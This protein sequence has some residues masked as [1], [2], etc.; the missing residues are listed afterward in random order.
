M[1]KT[2]KEAEEFCKQ[3][4]KSRN[5]GYIL[6]IEEKEKMS[7]V[8]RGHGEHDEKVGSGIKDIFI[9]KTVFGYKGFY[10]KRLDDSIIDFS[11]HHCLS[12]QKLNGKFSEAYRNAI[13][14]SVMEIQAS[15]CHNCHEAID[16]HDAHIHH[17]EPCTV[18]WQIKY[19]KTFYKIIPNNEMFEP[20]DSFLESFKDQDV[21]NKAIH[22]HDVFSKMVL[23][24]KPCHKKEHS[25]R[26]NPIDNP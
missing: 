20:A 1:F 9:E 3:L 4:L 2:K 14:Q 8:L 24:C 5:P 6:S 18:A 17:V 15:N 22:F 26:V 7:F 12:P 10:I 16:R 11:Y 19:F 21:K 23:L 13:F 25:R